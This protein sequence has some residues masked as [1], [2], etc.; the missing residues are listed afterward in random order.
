[1]PRVTK[2]LKKFTMNGFVS[3]KKGR[4]HDQRKRARRTENDGRS[5][6]NPIRLASSGMY[7]VGRKE[8]VLAVLSKVRVLEVGEKL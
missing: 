8:F 2:L 1:M 5:P 6:D 4:N 7:Q 3:Q